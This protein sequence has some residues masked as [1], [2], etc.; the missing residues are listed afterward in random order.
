MKSEGPLLSWRPTLGSEEFLFPNPAGISNNAKTAIR[1]NA[2]RLD[3]GPDDMSGRLKSYLSKNEK[4]KE[5]EIALF[6][7]STQCIESVLR[8]IKP[9]SLVM[10]GPL[11]R[12][13]DGIVGRLDLKT[14]VFPFSGEKGQTVDLDGLASV[15]R[16]AP[17]LLFPYPHDVTA[18]GPDFEP[19]CKFLGDLNRKG[20]TVIIDEAYREYGNLPSPVAVATASLR[21]IIVRTFSTFHGLAGLSLAVCIGPRSFVRALGDAARPGPVDRLSSVAA[22]A[23][24]RDKGFRKRT[25]EYLMKEKAFLVKRLE[26]CRFLSIQDRSADV[27]ILHFTGDKDGLKEKSD[28]FAVVLD[29]FEDRDGREFIRLPIADHASN[30]RVA[31]LLRSM[32]END[33]H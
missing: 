29:T 8:L 31:R 23:S 22:L 5:D 28:R 2:R 7:G 6:H 18:I 25:D 15:C 10:P 26:R 1:K 21:T 9:E 32:E 4:V 12:R 11:S 19:L 13:Y 30:A 33:G 17:A 20:K 14:V 16:T 24:L 27:L 3:L